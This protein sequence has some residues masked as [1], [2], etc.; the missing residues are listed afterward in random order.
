MS[1]V[2]TDLRNIVTSHPYWAAIVSVP[3]MLAGAGTLV[4]IAGLL[5]ADE[6]AGTLALFLLMLFRSAGVFIVAFL[7]AVVCVP[8]ITF[9]LAYAFNN[10]INNQGRTMTDD[11]IDNYDRHHKARFRE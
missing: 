11:L 9:F 4:I 6:G 8:V 10:L 5:L 7:L 3:V 2:I 1:R